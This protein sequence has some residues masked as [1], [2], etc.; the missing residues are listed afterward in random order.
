MI[1]NNDGLL[2]ELTEKLEGCLT[3]EDID[4][5]NKIIDET[6]NQIEMDKAK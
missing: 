3:K 4:R 1:I 6:L 2:E 5:I